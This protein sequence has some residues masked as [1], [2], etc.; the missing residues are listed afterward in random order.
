MSATLSGLVALEN[1]TSVE[2]SPSTLSFD[3]QIWLGLGRI[4]TGVFRYYNASNLSFPDVGQYFAW[5]HVSFTPLSIPL[6]TFSIQVAKFVAAIQN[7]HNKV[8]KADLVT[9]RPAKETNEADL[10][11]SEGSTKTLQHS[12]VIHVVGDII[13]VRYRHYSHYQY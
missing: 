3:G 9:E 4:L 6:L 7:E 2:D 10:P 12:P 13:H 5:I 8:A 11:S 1:A